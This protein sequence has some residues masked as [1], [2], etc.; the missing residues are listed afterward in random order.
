MQ[1]INQ[2]MDSLQYNKIQI[3][4]SISSSTFWYRNALL[5]ESTKTKEH[6]SHATFQVF[7]TISPVPKHVGVATHHALYFIVFYCMHLL[8]DILTIKNTC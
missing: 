3:N 4:M 1:Y 2:Q 6:K 8:V 7:I 5:W